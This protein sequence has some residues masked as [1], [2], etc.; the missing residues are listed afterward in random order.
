MHEHCCEDMTRHL[1]KMCDH[2][3]DAFECPDHVLT[4]APAFDEYGLIIHDGGSSS[5]E[6]RFCPFCGTRLPD[7]RRDEWFSK[8]EGLGF[9]TPFTD[10]RIPVECTSD[11]WYRT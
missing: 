3:D 5:Y 4:Y 8:L 6:I 1:G 7:S 11:A 10:D 2:H 9:E